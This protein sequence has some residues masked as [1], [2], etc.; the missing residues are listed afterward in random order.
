MVFYYHLIPA[1]YNQPITD[2]IKTFSEIGCTL[3][4]L[5]SKIEP[6]HHQFYDHFYHNLY[7]TKN[8]VYLSS[9]SRYSGE[10]FN[11]QN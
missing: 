11:F 9:V 6:R 10:S 1:K 5:N 2:K 4:K 7:F 3:V 8:L